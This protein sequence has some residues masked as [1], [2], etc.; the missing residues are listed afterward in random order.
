MPDPHGSRPDRGADRLLQAMTVRAAVAAGDCPGESGRRLATLLEELARG[1]VYP[2]PS[3]EEPTVP[4]CGGR[5]A[6]EADADRA[7]TAFLSRILSRRGPDIH[8]YL[9]GA[10]SYS[11]ERPV[12]EAHHCGR[13]LLV[14]RIV[15]RWTVGG[16]RD[17]YVCERC[18]PAYALPEGSRPPRRL[19]VHATRL[20]VEFAEPL[21]ADGWY[22]ACRQPVGGHPERPGALRRIGAGA[23]SLEVAL[24]AQDAPGLRRFAVA[25][26]SDGRCAV[27]QVPIQQHS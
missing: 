21:S 19:T 5:P 26:V 7:F 27:V 8:D 3:G 6:C 20:T 18:G 23:T 17:F 4:S 22:T 1:A 9:S 2:A 16:V 10:V 15:P 13:R 14:V 11:P 12:A 25:L 24:P